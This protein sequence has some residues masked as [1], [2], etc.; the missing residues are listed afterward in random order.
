MLSQSQKNYL[1]NVLGISEWLKPQKMALPLTSKLIQ[2]NAKTWC[3]SQATKLAIVHHQEW[4][5]VEKNLIEKIL[6]AAKI[7]DWAEC[8]A[9]E[10]LVGSKNKLKLEAITSPLW[11]IIFG[12]EDWHE[13]GLSLPESQAMGHILEWEGKKVLLTH[14]LQ[15]MLD[16]HTG[17]EIKKNVWQHM[18]LLM[19]EWS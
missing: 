1:I 18:K 16:P 4:A 5:P 3:L 6:A 15:E 7:T 19:R 10:N 9:V 8:V 2:E 14:S 17:Q 13:F 12:A 11:I